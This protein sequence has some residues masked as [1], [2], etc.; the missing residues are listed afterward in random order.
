MN[1]RLTTSAPLRA[2]SLSLAVAAATAALAT[3]P[4][5]AEDWQWS[6][7]PYVWATDLGIG[8]S[9]AERELLDT[10]VAF[11]DLVEKLDS[12]AMV[13]I[14]GM[15]G[16]HGMAFDVF[17]V[18]LVDAR[19]FELPGAPSTDVAFDTSVGLSILD[20]TGVYD[21]RGD[22]KGF[23]I[24]YGA[25]VIEQRNEVGSTLS[26]DG[27]AI[28]N[29]SYAA[30]DRFVDG[31]VG[32]RYVRELPH[33]LSYGFAADVSTGG[34]ELTWSAG[35]ALGYTFGDRGRYRVTAGYRRMDIDFETADPV[36]ADM[37][38]DG[39]LLGVRIDF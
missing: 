35:P 7:T 5:S 37:S 17:N 10:E 19:S 38:M 23:S 36:G 15:H 33:N 24:V 29:R 2:R 14:E 28:A 34:T 21:P 25:R 18:E 20:A 32:F 12:A 27:T 13:R 3:T 39:L 9:V 4:A 11:D 22:G 30:T 6:A 26:L 16:R 31:L 1:T 8:L